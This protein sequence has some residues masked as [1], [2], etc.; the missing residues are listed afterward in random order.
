MIPNNVG[1]EKMLEEKKLAGYCGMYCSAC[2]MHTGEIKATVSRLK[3]LVKIYDLARVAQLL[4]GIR[5]FPQFQKVLDDLEKMFGTCVGCR[6][7]GGWSDCP[8]RK[9]CVE[10]NLGSCHEC[11]KMPCPELLKFQRRHFLIPAPHYQKA[12]GR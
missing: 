5:G 1:E 2:A 7:G 8:M 10:K 3:E 4:G 11:D 6:A 9:C 12:L